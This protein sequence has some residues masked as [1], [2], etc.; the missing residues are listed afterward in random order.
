MK[1]KERVSGYYLILGYLGIITI[2]VGVITLL[3]LATLLFYP[4]E[5]NQLSYFVIPGVIA[6]LIGYLL[7]FIIKGKELE[8]LQHNQELLI[9]LGTW[10]IAI[11]ITALPFYLTGE[12]TLT[13]AIF[14]TTSGLSTTGLSVV[15]TSQ[16]SHLFLMHRTITLFVGGVGL[17]LVM[18]SI[19]SDIYGM[20]L[21]TA[22][23]H[24][25]KLLPNLFKSARLIIA[26][27]SGYILAGIILYMLAGMSTFD[28][29]AHS[30]AA[31]STGG[32]STHPE[33]IG[34]YHSAL[35]EVITIVLMLLGGTNFFVHLLLLKGKFKDVLYH[36]ETRLTLMVT[37]FTTVIMAVILAEGTYNNLTTEL[38]IALFQIVSAIT[39]TGF[40]TVSTFNYWAPSLLLIMTVV[41]LIGGSSGST[42]GGIKSYR[43][44]LLYKQ[45]T[46]EIK[47]MINS[48]RMIIPN[49]IYKYDQNEVITLK[50]CHK[51]NIY[52]II[53]LIIFIL[54]T[55]IFCLFGHSIQ[56]AMFEFASALSTVG[57]SMG[58]ACKGASP[59]ILWTTILGMFLGRLEIYIVL[60][61][62]IKLCQDGKRKIMIKMQGNRNEKE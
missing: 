10:I 24:N 45:I 34:Y 14:E 12:Y 19:M 23:G 13:E 33:S 58:I 37:A 4:E 50:E 20:R 15:D 28:A 59:V 55:F 26:I 38:R 46:W 53:Y 43:V 9:V 57:L 17:V 21:Y 2:M 3:P 36:C 51:V 48:K 29:I 5:S 44:Y 39:T 41:M 40:Q 22:E 16:A 56:A 1:V 11:F 30:V 52:V 54:G 7:S 27:Y 8:H 62:I 60:I 32:F 25:D 42:A 18:T 31:L 61:S 49:N 35:I 6:I 47:K